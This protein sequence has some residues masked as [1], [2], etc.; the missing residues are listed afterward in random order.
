[1]YMV[2]YNSQFEKVS[3]GGT[4]YKLNTAERMVEELEEAVKIGKFHQ[5]LDDDIKYNNRALNHLFSPSEKDYILEL[6]ISISTD[7]SIPEEEFIEIMEDRELGSD[8]RVVTGEVQA[9]DVK[10]IHD[11]TEDL[12]SFEV[13]IP[14]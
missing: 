2:E 9:L 14:N 10:K 11:N 13:K 1:M 8:M 5:E 12:I 6:D 7:G 3:I 4:L